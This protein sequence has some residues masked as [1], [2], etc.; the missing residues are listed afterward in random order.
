M[1][2]KYR[3]VEPG[4]Y[5]T[6]Q[7]FAAD[8]AAAKADGF[9]SVINNRPDGEGGLGQPPSQE[10]RAAAQDAGLVYRHLPVPPMGH[11]LEDA[12]RMVELVRSLPRPIVAFCRT[13]MRSAALYQKG[14][15]A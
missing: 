15:G 10:L 5:V 12:Q 14:K 1:E 13:G 7:L 9:A 11:N 2:E 3:P 6:P 8:L 4:F